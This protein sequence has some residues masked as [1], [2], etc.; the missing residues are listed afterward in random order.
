MSKTIQGF[1]ENTTTLQWSKIK[2]CFFIGCEDPVCA[3]LNQC[4]HKSGQNLS[5]KQ[6]LNL[7]KL[8]FSKIHWH[9][10]QHNLVYKSQRFNFKHRFSK[11]NVF[12]IHFQNNSSDCKFPLCQLG[13]FCL[14]TKPSLHFLYKQIENDLKAPKNIEILF[15]HSLG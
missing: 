9:L 10:R 11:P 15:K 12:I 14:H 13:L 6:Y 1:S 3:V 8:L 7:R 4:V 5:S 2:F